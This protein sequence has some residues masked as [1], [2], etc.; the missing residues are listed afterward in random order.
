M[1]SPRNGNSVAEEVK[2]L[3]AFLAG[4]PD[5]D[6]DKHFCN[7]A[8]QG[9][10]TVPLT[11]PGSILTAIV[12]DH[13]ILWD[14]LRMRPAKLWPDWPSV[15]V[16]HY[17]PNHA[18]IMCFVDEGEELGGEGFRRCPRSRLLELTQDANTKHRLDF[19]IGTEIEFFIMQD[20][21]NGPQQ[22]DMIPNTYSAASMNNDYLSVVEEIVRSIAKAG[23]P[24]RQ[25]YSE[26]GPGAFEIS[27]EPLPPLQSAD[28]LV[29]SQEAIK[30]ICRKHGLHGTMFPK[31]FEKLTGIGLHYHLSMFPNDQGDSFLAGLLDHWKALAAFYLPN[32][33][34]YTR[35]KP[36]A[37]VTWGFENRTNPH[38][39]MLG[40]IT[41]GMLGLKSRQELNMKDCD[42]TMG[43]KPLDKKELEEYGVIDTIPTSLKEALHA[44]RN[45]EALVDKLKPAIVDKYLTLKEKE[46][47]TFSKLTLSERKQISMQL[48]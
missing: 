47:E 35:V 14:N 4:N 12:I 30:W 13:D 7:V 23:I 2:M 15:R 1:G 39:V 44:L 19:L 43:F 20:T 37:Q 45:D 11:A 26:G 32:Y 28:A 41:A 27:M 33:D 34:S 17:Y 24:V 29:Y 10:T 48:F 16:W 46:N 38:L 3:E 25:F 31:P 42:K 18:Q 6:T 21:K 36:G 8:R 5:V 40:V 22:V 9:R